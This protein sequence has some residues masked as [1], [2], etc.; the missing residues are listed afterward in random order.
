MHNIGAVLAGLACVSHAR[1]AQ[2]SVDKFRLSFS[3][4]VNSPHDVAH[5]NS[6]HDVD[7]FRNFQPPNN[8]GALNI[9]AKLLLTLNPGAAFACFKSGV[10]HGVRNSTLAK[11]LHC[12]LAWRWS[13]ARSAVQ[14]R[15]RSPLCVRDDMDVDVPQAINRS[16]FII[17]TVEAD[18]LPECANVLVET[19]Q[20]CLIKAA[21]EELLLPEKVVEALRPLLTFLNEDYVRF[22]KKWVLEL[23]QERTKGRIASG[24]LR[25]GIVKEE[26][27]QF[28]INEDVLMLALK[29]RETGSI[30]G[31]A[32]LSE[33]PLDG[34][35]P[36]DLRF[37]AL[38]WQSPPPRCAYVCNLGVRREWQ[39]RGL[40]TA[41]LSVCENIA[42][43]WGFND[44]Y[45]HAAK[46]Q[47]RLMRWYETLKYEPM[48]SYDQPSWIAALSGRVETLYFRKAVARDDSEL[49]SDK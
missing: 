20:R 35:V 15:S 10:L 4:H 17:G 31:V 13:V 44:L 38:P 32:E 11:P 25:R 27:F 21:K 6:P 47:D 29:D 39:G 3:A 5:V 40:G 28:G 18:D 24:G 14:A 9:F 46:K 37:P 12:D 8:K 48:P 49:D 23:I 26:E 34:K 1:R 36:G 41:M 2:G 42:A 7:D 30:V 33:Q 16:A 45:L 22:S 43:H 19:F